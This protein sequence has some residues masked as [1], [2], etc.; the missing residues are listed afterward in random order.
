MGTPFNFAMSGIKLSLPA[1]QQRA[2]TSDL[3][4]AIAN[5]LAQ[6]SNNN[7]GVSTLNLNADGSYNPS[8]MQ[9]LMNKMDELISA[10]RR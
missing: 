4:N 5:A 6:T 3:N 1:S 2:T 7:N 9:D 8:Q 10:L